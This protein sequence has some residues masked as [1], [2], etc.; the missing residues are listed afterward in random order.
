MKAALLFLLM[1]SS[2]F[3]QFSL[4]GTVTNAKTGEPVVRA[5]VQVFRAGS[6]SF[7]ARTM[8][9][10]AGMFQL[11]GLLPGSYSISAQKPQ[12]T[13]ANREVLRTPVQLTA[14]VSD[15]KLSLAPLGVIAGRVVDQDGQPVW[16]ASV[17]LVTAP[18]EDGLRQKKIDR[19]VTTDE[20]GMFRIWN[21]APGRY[22]LKAAGRSGGSF[23]Y[24]GDT[25]P[26]FFGD[27][28]FEPVYYMGGP[29]LDSA[30]PLEIQ[31]GTEVQADLKVKIVQAHAIRGSLGNFVP[32]RAVHFE[33]LTRGESQPASPVSV[34]AETGRFELQGVTPGSYVLHATQDNCSGDVAVSMEASDLAGVALVLNPAVDLKIVTRVTN[35]L[36]P[37]APENHAFGARFQGASCTVL[38]RAT[39]GLAEERPI[40]ARALPNG[41]GAI[42]GVIPGHY[43]SVVTCFGGYAQSAMWGT[44]DLLANPLMS[45][46]P[47]SDTQP[48]EIVARRG[49]GTITGS[50]AEGLTG[51]PG[52]IMVLAVPQFP[53]ST[54]PATAAVN[55][56]SFE[57]DGLAPGSYQIYAWR[58]QEGP[59]FR[60]P[61]ALQ[62]L[63]DALSVQV[64]EGS[65][66]T[67]TITKVMP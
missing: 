11:A 65:R 8:T 24:S 23:S 67:V 3:G 44:Q 4:G 13:M 56:D 2:A 53:G 18:V 60:N 30:M 66:K 52:L 33:L 34:N 28:G 35:P 14:S 58:G 26:Q 31:P 49:G 1:G 25:T 16:A 63:T 38:L 43:R 42:S 32:R 57:I 6:P 51:K 29:T 45:V 55:G 7:I 15:V 39:D 21:L 12:F 50:L 54:G 48:I 61:P 40:G 46:A 27:Q 59:E 37:D 19:T 62:M 47:G 20:R 64:E 36:P 10:A 9:D 41:Q 17:A 5:M 22:Y